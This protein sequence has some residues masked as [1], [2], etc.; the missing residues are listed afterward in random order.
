MT[1]IYRLI[2][3]ILLLLPVASIQAGGHK[4]SNPCC[5][6][7]QCPR[8]DHVCEFSVDL[9]DEAKNCY[10]VEE[11]AVCIPNVVLP[12]QR[13][14]CCGSPSCD[15]SC[16]GACDGYCDG[17]CNGG[18]G[19]KCCR[20]NN[21]ACKKY[22]RV[23]KKFE[24]QCKVCKYEWNAELPSCNGDCCA[25]GCCDEGC[26]ANVEHPIDSERQL[27]DVPPA[28]PEPTA[29]KVQ[30]RGFQIVKKSK[31]GLKKRTKALQAALKVWSK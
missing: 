10:C 30:D 16:D 25:G 23:L 2:P 27:D 11:K 28:P 1:N 9:E 3:V 5:C 24:Y 8:C 13:K 21:G 20:Y 19:V 4:G 15:G 22:V 29:G 18:C 6:S 7:T 17:N 12:W 14:A 26:D 31:I